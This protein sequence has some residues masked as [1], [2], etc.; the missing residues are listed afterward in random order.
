[1]ENNKRYQMILTR[2]AYKWQAMGILPDRI[3]PSQ[4]AIDAMALLW[5]HI[6][7]SYR[8]SWDDISEYNRLDDSVGLKSLGKILKRQLR[9]DTKSIAPMVRDIVPNLGK[10][11]IDSSGINTTKIFRDIAKLYHYGHSLSEIANILGLRA[12]WIKRLREDIKRLNPGLR[13]PERS[14]RQER[15]KRYQL[16]LKAKKAEQAIA[17]PKDT[18]AHGA[19]C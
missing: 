12:K 10:T 8:D 14:K 9:S 19:W 6:P 11:P 13:L 5:E 15:N 4:L 18:I 17:L 7:Q 3:K 2:I 1:M 16:K